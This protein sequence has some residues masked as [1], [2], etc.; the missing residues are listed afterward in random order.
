ML[1]GVS[2]GRHIASYGIEAALSGGLPRH[3]ALAF[4]EEDAH[5][6]SDLQRN[7]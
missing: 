1:Q 3:S 5:P 2:Y 7:Y 4:L 6:I